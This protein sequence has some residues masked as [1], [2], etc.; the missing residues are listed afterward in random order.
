[1]VNPVDAN[2]FEYEDYSEGLSSA[3]T[4]DNKDP[5]CSEGFRNESRFI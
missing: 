1:M 3:L 4:L 5:A 2:E